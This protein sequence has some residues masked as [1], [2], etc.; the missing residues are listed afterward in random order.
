MLRLFRGSRSAGD[1]AFSASCR[2]LSLFPLIAIRV[3]S[4]ASGPVA[5]GDSMQKAFGF[6]LISLFSLAGGAMAQSEAD[7]P[8]SDAALRRI[9]I[10]NGTP[11]QLRFARAVWG[12]AAGGRFR[13]VHAKPGDVVPIVAGADVSIGGLVAIR[14]GSAGEATVRNVWMPVRD[15][16]GSQYHCTC[17]S[18]HL[19]W[20]KSINGQ[21]IPL[22]PDVKGKNRVVVYDVFSTHTGAIA[23]PFHLR[24]GLIDA[25]TF[26]SLVKMV[27][28]RDWLPAGTRTTVYVD[29]NFPLFA[30]EVEEDQAGL[31]IPNESGSVMIYRTKGQ[32]DRQL[33]VYCDSR[34]VGQ[35]GSLQYVEIEMLPGNHYCQ[36]EQAG[37]LEFSVTGGAE[38]YLYLEYGPFSGS[39]KLSV[40]NNLEGEDGIGAADLVS[41]SQ[42]TNE[43]H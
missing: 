42:P 29:G 12:L 31:P 1:T 36:A 19:D 43:T 41:N 6:I 33:H 40:V 9:T 27:H 3:D 8:K 34:E 21:L 28:E 10:P 24:R 4:P 18:L 22:R 20:I 26:T 11:V 35:L 13:P 37:K 15:K 5:Q 38:H 7:S 25:F 2:I 14:K 17:F 39:W 23:K 16:H 30:S 32:K